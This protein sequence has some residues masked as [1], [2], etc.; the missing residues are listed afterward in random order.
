[1]KVLLVNGSP[2]AKSHFEKTAQSSKYILKNSNEIQSG[3]LKNDDKIQNV[4]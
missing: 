2:S 1:M 3:I 4:F